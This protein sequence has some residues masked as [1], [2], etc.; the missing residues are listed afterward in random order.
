V[1]S[2]ATN[3]FIGIPVFSLSLAA[4]VSDGLRFPVSRREMVAFVV[5]RRMAA[6]S[7]VR[8]FRWRQAFSGS[9]P[10]MPKGYHIGNPSA[11]GG[12]PFWPTIFQAGA[13]TILVM[14]PRIG[15]RRPV[16][17]YLAK[18]R[19]AHIPKLTQEQL[20][21]R[22]DPPVDKGT[23]S[24][25]ES[26]PPGKLSL[27]VIAAYA[28]AL[29]REAADMYRPPDTGPSLD[30]IAAGLEPDLRES[31]ANFIQVLKNKRAS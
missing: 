21:Q 27:G 12:F 23:V 11:I 3:S 2:A 25:W 17:V 29:G 14:P 30:A 28:E 9:M 26:A 10:S 7:C 24:R 20:G 31:V 5:S 6:A 22:I 13:V 19:E 15:P 8:P 16:R 4:S 18:W 1:T